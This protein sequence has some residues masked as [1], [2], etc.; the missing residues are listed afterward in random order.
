MIKPKQSK[1]KQNKQ[2]KKT[3]QQ[4]QKS[5]NKIYRWQR[6]IYATL[7]HMLSGKHKSKQ[8]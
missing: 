3:Q 8:Q 6:N 1:T 4:K 7:Y 2:T 5:Q